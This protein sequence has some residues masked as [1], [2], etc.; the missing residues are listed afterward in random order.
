ML[1]SLCKTWGVV[2][3][4]VCGVCGL[5]QRVSTHRF[6][7]LFLAVEKTVG[8]APSLPHFLPKTIHSKICGFV[9]VKRL[10]LP[11]SHR[12]Y[13]NNNELSNLITV[14]GGGAK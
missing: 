12:T 4:L 8:Y 3:G 13:K 10:L 7:V 5:R 14:F 9:S 2:V 1:S 11:T 6:N